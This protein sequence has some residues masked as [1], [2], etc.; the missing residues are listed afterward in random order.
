M[1]R[2][3]SE[4][5][6]VRKISYEH[7]NATAYHSAAL[8]RDRQAW[9]FYWGLDAEQGLG[10]Y[11]AEAVAQLKADGRHIATY[12]FVRPLIDNLAGAILKTPF[13]FD[14]SPVDDELSTLTY[15]A[16][17]AF[18]IDREQ[19]DWD[20]TYDSIVHG[21]LIHEAV[22]EMYV[23]KTWDPKFGNVGL[24]YRLPGTVK[25]DPKW[26]SPKSK[27]C[28]KCWV[29]TMMTPAE[30]LEI[31]EDNQTEIMA[32]VTAAA[33]QGDYK[34]ILEDRL[35]VMHE[36]GEEFGVNEGIFVR[37]E[38]ENKILG[39]QYNVVSQYEMVKT[40]VPTS[41]VITA[42]GKVTIP[43]ECQSDEDKLAWLN[44]N[45]PDW[46][47]EQVFDDYDEVMIQH[48]T[49]IC[50]TLS[51]DLIIQDK[52][53][54]LQLGRLQFFPVSAN[55]KNGQ[56]S[57]VCDAVRD[58]QMQINY[59]ESILTHKIQVEGGG[60]AQF[61]DPDGFDE[62]SEIKKYISGRNNP[63]ETF[64]LRRG[65]LAKNP[66][67]PAIPVRKSAFPQEVTQHLDH[68]IDSVL[69]RITPVTPASQGRTESSNES[70]YLYRL[71][72][73][74]S[75]TQQYTIYSALKRWWNEIGE[76][77]LMAASTL[78]GNG[79]E[80]S[81]FNQA[82]KSSFK[83]NE[84][85]QVDGMEVIV[86]D[87][88]RLRDLRHRVIVTESEDSPTRK[89]EAM[90][91][92]AEAMKAMP[93]FKTLTINKM[94]SI[95]ARNVDTFNEEDRA[96][97]DRYDKLESDVA[98]QQMKLNLLKMKIEEANIMQQLAPQPLA[99]PPAGGPMPPQ[100]QPPMAMSPNPAAPA[101]PQVTGGGPQAP[102][103]TI[104]RGS[105]QPTRPAPAPQPQGA[106]A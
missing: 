87:F 37:S 85:R 83:I 10:Q 30:M 7:G 33:T 14:F 80:R 11:P 48:L 78:Y 8:E 57:G 1:L 74:Q 84:H 53:T 69:P 86:N 103:A 88:S 60:G 20:T 42:M 62:D 34:Q 47:P 25:F 5:E 4:S 31:F 75:D 19:L 64:R 51:S 27:E 89:I 65:Y 6:R 61:V 50:P 12:N 39:T 58:L 92:A 17:D 67:G 45:V 100:G 71:K 101:N 81:F 40:R 21:M 95:I 56:A 96:D 29:D 104:S 99:Q 28:K 94:S 82:T 68:L 43:S 55:R 54:R 77:Y 15:A 3:L 76:G 91:V 98:E 63:R 59:W 13:S 26:K 102:A 105:P 52:P 79:L 49:I 23:D 36:T 9:Q 106:L 32:A 38:D 24:R 22:A 97:L 70:G 44:N 90:S 41:F 73:I 35:K 16:K 2:T 66:N 72:K 93:Q 46:Q 18:F